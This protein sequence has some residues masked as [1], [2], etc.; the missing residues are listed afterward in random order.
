MNENFS[1]TVSAVNDAPTS[2]SGAL[3][4]FTA[5][6][7]D[8]S[9]S[10]AVSLG[11]TSVAYGGGGGSEG[12]GNGLTSAVRATPSFVTLWKADGVTSVTTSSTL[13]AAELQGLKYKTVADAK[14]GRASC[15]ERV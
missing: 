7:E 11:L 14:I 10:T 2:T 8:A 6:N 5:V 3:P 12:C 1:V 9:N 13:T 4:T 15:R